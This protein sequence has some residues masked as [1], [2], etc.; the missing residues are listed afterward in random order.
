MLALTCCFSSTVIE[1]QCLSSFSIHCR[2]VSDKFD[3][4]LKDLTALWLII[5]KPIT[6]KRFSRLPLCA[7]SNSYFDLKL[8]PSCEPIWANLT[9]VEIPIHRPGAVLCLLHLCSNICSSAIRMSSS[10]VCLFLGSTVQRKVGAQVASE[11]F[12][13]RSVF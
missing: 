3:P 6:E 2:V 4:L 5:D 9:I 11:T 7:G 13:I 8:L 1:L 10:P 12:D